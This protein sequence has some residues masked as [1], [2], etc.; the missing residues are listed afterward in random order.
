MMNLDDAF[1]E[2]WASELEK[3]KTGSHNAYFAERIYPGDLKRAFAAG[4][5]SQAETIRE[6]N[7]EIDELKELKV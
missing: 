7:R 2:W 6:L 1:D 4:V 3:M 5:V